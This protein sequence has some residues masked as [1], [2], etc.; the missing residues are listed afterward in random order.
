MTPKLVDRLSKLIPMLGSDKDFEVLA[1]R[2][3]LRSALASEKL[4]FHDLAKRLCSGWSASGF[5]ASGF[6]DWTADFA[7]RD[8]ERE[9]YERAAE[10]E[11]V[12]R[13]EAYAAKKAAKAAARAAERASP[14]YK[15][16]VA[17][18]RRDAL[19]GRRAA[20]A[21]VEAERKL[22]ER[23]AAEGPRWGDIGDAGRRA[24]VRKIISDPSANLDPSAMEAL[25]GI[26]E[27]LAPTSP[28]RRGRRQKPKITWEMITPAW[29]AG[30]EKAARDHT[31][32]QRG[33]RP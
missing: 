26:E 16:R 1:A 2:G 33:R 20:E 28:S 29:I 17:Q 31:M 22:A 9:A 12:K 3:R 27:A 6:S 25:N 21:A 11:R 30:F 32:R 19:A 24:W 7:R 10:A 15:A 4:D 13:A 5:D 8:A 18:R 14:E 23:I